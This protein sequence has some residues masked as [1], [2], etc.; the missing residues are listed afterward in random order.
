[1]QEAIMR[2]ELFY[3]PTIQ[4]RGEFIRLAL[5]DAGADYLDVGNGREADE[6]GIPAI[7]SY[8]DGDAT[9]RPPFAPPFL[10]AGDLVISHVA[11][12]LH[13][14][15]PRLGLVPDDEA[16]RYWAHGLQLTLADLV[17]EIHD[18]HHPIAASLYYQDQQTEAKRRARVFLDERLPRFLG[19]FEQVLEQNPGGPDYLVGEAHSYADLSLFHVTTGL[20]YAFPNAM[21]EHEEEHPKVIA[22][23]ERVA[24]RPNIR[25]YL[26]SPRRLPFNEDGIF[27]HYP[28]LDC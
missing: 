25:A 18:V 17:A 5:E 12:I 14:L 9:P 6:M 24:L 16:C 21:A 11:N 3:W 8:L 1:M 23:T 4:G 13:Y 10:K 26:A 20:R 22:L 28:E 7:A 2:Y 19:Y 27:R 15:G